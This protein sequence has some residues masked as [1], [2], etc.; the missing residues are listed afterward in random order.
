MGASGA[1]VG[2]EEVHH[3]PY[4][5][6]APHR[7]H[8][9]HRI[10]RDASRRRS[11]RTVDAGECFKKG[12]EVGPQVEVPLLATAGGAADLAAPVD[13]SKEN[14]AVAGLLSWAG[15]NRTSD[16]RIISRLLGRVVSTAETIGAAL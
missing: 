3:A 4:R 13:T 1:S 15:R 10:R 6:Q 14:P 12:S 5:T 8:A 16:R 9:P 2:R 7:T 11:G